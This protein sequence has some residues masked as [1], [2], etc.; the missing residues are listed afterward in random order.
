MNTVTLSW[1]DPE[2]A[3]RFLQLREEYRARGWLPD[4]SSEELRRLTAECEV[5]SGEGGSDD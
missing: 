4:P 2:D 1:H 5:V 3:E